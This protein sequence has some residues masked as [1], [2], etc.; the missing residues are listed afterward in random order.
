MQLEGRQVKR[1]RLDVMMDF[2]TEEQ[3]QELQGVLRE[4]SEKI[5]PA[6]LRTHIFVSNAAAMAKLFQE[7]Y[8]ETIHLR[9]MVDAK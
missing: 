6:R 8:T 9:T 4:E 2:T 3:L 7:K 5:S 1:Q